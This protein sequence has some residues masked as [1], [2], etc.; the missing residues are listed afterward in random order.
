MIWWKTVVVGCAAAAALSGCGDPQERLR[1]HLDRARAYYVQDRFELSEAEL[2]RALAIDPNHVEALYLS[3]AAQEKQHRLREAFLQYLRTLELQ[4]QHDGARVRIG[5]ILLLTGHVDKARAHAEAI[6][7]RAPRNV[8]ALVLLAG[9]NQREGKQATAMRFARE[10]VALNPRHGEAVTMLAAL[11]A[12]RGDRAKAVQVLSQGVA[13]SPAD[14]QL[15]VALVTLSLA[16]GHYEAAAKQYHEI[17]AIEPDRMEH[18]VALARLYSERDELDKAEATLR[19]AVAANPSDIRRHVLLADFLITRRDAVRA[20]QSLLDAIKQRPRAWALHFRLAALY[21]AQGEMAGAEEIYRRVIELDPRGGSGVRARTE[22]ARARLAEGR[23]R[24]AELLVQQVLALAPDDPAAR[25]LRARMALGKGEPGR[26]VAD[27]QVVREQRPDSL[28]VAAELGKAYVALGDGE[29]AKQAVLQ[30]IARNPR[31]YDLR[32]LLAEVKLALRDFG[33]A[34]E[35]LALALLRAPT[36]AYALA[37]LAALKDARGDQ[38]G[39]EQTLRSLAAAYPGDAGV[40]QRLG[41]FYFAA[42]RFSE[43]ARAFSQALTLV[44]HAIEPLTGLVNVHVSRGAPKRAVALV[45]HEAKRAPGNFLVW[46]LL[47]HAYSANRQ[48]AK[49]EAAFRKAVEVNPRVAGAHVELVRFLATRR[50]GDK[51]I[52]AAERGLR[53][54]SGDRSLSF[55]LAELH[56]SGGR[57]DEAMRVYQRSV[58][59]DP[60]DDVAANNLASLLLDQ[61]DDAASHRRAL[62]LASRFE[63]SIQPLFL[64]TLGWA[65]YRLGDYDRAVPILTQAAQ[66]APDTALV[67]F[68]LG[69]ALHDAGEHAQARERLQKAI[70]QRLAAPESVTARQV[71]AA[72]PVARPVH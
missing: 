62:Q 66:R 15:R 64:D 58:A 25:L 13:A 12:A 42:G 72:G 20:E 59:A 27:L 23:S 45:E 47:G 49:A 24:D 1:A 14:T 30:A 22:L 5:S 26:A 3:G 55:Q 44:P 57:L 36:D 56:R 48:F 60:G 28:E 41:T 8:D 4:P 37:V 39:A 35:D 40:L 33:G 61:R 31:S 52:A 11:H 19:D 53:T 9:I 67:Q 17:I 16:Q 2:R 65:W 68:H 50:Q 46:V 7:R 63:T 6:L 21:T 18:R 70:E 10:A 32:V 38:A 29:A 69:M 71:L 51:A 43:A 54:L 34:G